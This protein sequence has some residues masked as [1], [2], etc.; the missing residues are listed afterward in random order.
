[1]VIKANCH[2]VPRREEANLVALKS[3]SFPK[4]QRECEIGLAA[5]WGC[6]TGIWIDID[7]KGL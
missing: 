3:R 1:M 7:L 6:P 5:R 2:R 4:S